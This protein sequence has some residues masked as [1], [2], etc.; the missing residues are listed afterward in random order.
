MSA[1]Y[2]A[3]PEKAT[4]EGFDWLTWVRGASPSVLPVK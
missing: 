2:I 4:K 1:S 3:L